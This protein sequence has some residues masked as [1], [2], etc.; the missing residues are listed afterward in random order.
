MNALVE[1]S[2]PTLIIFVIS[3][4]IGIYA[5]F[6]PAAFLYFVFIAFSALRLNYRLC[7]FTG[8]VAAFGYLLVSLL[9][10]SQNPASVPGNPLFSTTIIV[11]KSMMMLVVGSVT[12]FVAYQI[13]KRIFNSY[14]TTEERNRIEKMF[15]QHVSSAVV[16]RL[17]RQ[18][19]A[20]ESE[21]RRVCVMFL[22]IR[23]F[24]AFADRN[25]PQAVV[26][27]LNKLF[28]FMIEIINKHH[29]IINKFLGDGFMAVFGAPFSDEQDSS[30]AVRSA[31]AIIERVN[32][33]MGDGRI[34]P[35]R[36]GIGLHTGE[37]I[38]G[39][40]GSSLRRE[41]TIIGDVVNLAA[42]IESLNKHFD[43]QLLISE[44]VWNEVKQDGYPVQGLG[45]VAIRGRQ[46]A[47]PLY[48]LC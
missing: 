36:V 16:E 23:N 48:Q 20:K 35:T 3:R 1:T 30:N 8:A 40:I 2:L 4:F 28:P 18:S 43:S 10:R 22:D 47:I 38:T 26:D 39:N 37:A 5:L 24:T 27:Y 32:H 6:T 25:T 34:P 19:R 21:L 7:L 11:N 15:G 29:G 9:V 33:E 46:E 17:L 13:K 12:A 45:P 14:R 41:Y 42:R 44:A 31:L